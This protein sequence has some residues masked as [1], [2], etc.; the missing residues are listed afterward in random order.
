MQRQKKLEEIKQNGQL[1]LSTSGGGNTTP[2]CTE[3]YV[4]NASLSARRHIEQV[5]HVIIFPMHIF[6]TPSPND[7]VKA[8]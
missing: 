3:W 7:G 2:N 4:A 5:G 6:P 8:V 1:G